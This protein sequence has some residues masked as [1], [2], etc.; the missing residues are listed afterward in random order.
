MELVWNGWNLQVDFLY[1][2]TSIINSG[3]DK[4]ICEKL[5]DYKCDIYNFWPDFI[6]LNRNFTVK[7]TKNEFN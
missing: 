1:H 5:I 7:F 6:I 2:F 3:K 4:K